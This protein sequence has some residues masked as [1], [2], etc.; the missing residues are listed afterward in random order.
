VELPPIK[1]TI[2]KKISV[3]GSKLRAV[4]VNKL[5]NGAKVRSKGRYTGYGEQVVLVDHYK[6]MK[7]LYKEHGDIGV[8]T[9]MIQVVKEADE[10]I[11]TRHMLD[12]KNK[13]AEEE[14]IGDTPLAEQIEEGDVDDEFTSDDLGEDEDDEEELGGEA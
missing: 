1:K 3:P 11:K 12:P 8:K 9:Y 14:S 10:R 7:V 4:G 2:R 13:P 6:R 5:N